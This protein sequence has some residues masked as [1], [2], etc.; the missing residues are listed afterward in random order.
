MSSAT[1]RSGPSK[2]GSEYSRPLS[3]SVAS[4][5]WFLRSFLRW[6]GQVADVVEQGAHAACGDLS[7]KRGHAVVAAGDRLRQFLVR[8]LLNCRQAQVAHR[9]L[10][11][12]VRFAAPVLCMANGALGLDPELRRVRGQGRRHKEKKRGE[13]EQQRTAHAVQLAARATAALMSSTF[14]NTRSL[15]RQIFFCIF[16]PVI[17]A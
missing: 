8:H 3:S 12:D 15:M 6:S 11:A 9:A 14:S 5:I 10:P 17:G 4:F 13:D 16:L 1:S 7:L 2:T